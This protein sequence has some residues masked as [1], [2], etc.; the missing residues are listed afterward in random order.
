MIADDI[1]NQEHDS[2]FNANNLASI[3]FKTFFVITIL[4]AFRIQSSY[5]TQIAISVKLEIAISRFQ[6]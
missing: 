3:S 4:S 1:L 6:H 2:L 5:Q